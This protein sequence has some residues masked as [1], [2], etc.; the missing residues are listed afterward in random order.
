MPKLPSGLS[1]AVSRHALFNHGGNWFSCPEG[2]FWYWEPAPEIGPPPFDPESEI[3]LVAKHAPVPR[4]REEAKQ[5]IRVLE[6]RPDGKYGWRGELLNSFPKFF[7]LDENDASAWESW[8]KSPGTERFLDDTIEECKKL[9]KVSENVKGY[10]VVEEVGDQTPDSKGRIKGN[11]RVPNVAA[12]ELEMDEVS[13]DFSN[14]WNAAGSHLQHQQSQLPKHLYQGPIPN[15]LKVSLTPPFL[16]HL[17]FRLGNQLFFVRLEDV[18]CRLEVPGSLSGLLMIS[19]S[20]KGHPCIMPMRHK[21]G[22]WYP[23]AAGW[24][25]INA[26]NGEEVDPIALISDALIEMTDWELQD[27]AVQIVRGY[28]E[29]EG[30][31]IMSSQGNPQTNPSIWFVGDSG[32]EWVVVRATRYPEMDAVPP[33]N[34]SSIANGCARMSTLGHF[35]SVSV[36]SAD[37]AF[38]PSVPPTPL[39]RGHGTIVRFVGLVPGPDKI[40]QP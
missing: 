39:W 14:C 40:R 25:L 5:F 15:W 20:C 11:L 28:L 27:F 31:K 2:H 3:E 12:N 9:A 32:P 18:E 21:V 26:L 13:V 4:S 29:K 34:W 22:A 6:M 37:D 1:L 36:A 38:D 19:D 23:D 16:E 33:E 7:R 35:A 24:G 10:A 8:V 17:S 30:K